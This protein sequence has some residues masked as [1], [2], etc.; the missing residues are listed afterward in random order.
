MDLT[1]MSTGAYYLRIKR[2]EQITTHKVVY[3]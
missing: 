1:A 3:K 2:G